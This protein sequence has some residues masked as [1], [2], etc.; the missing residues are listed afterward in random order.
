M[1]WGGVGCGGER[2]GRGGKGWVV[3]VGEGGGEH[4]RFAWHSEVMSVYE[5][6]YTHHLKLW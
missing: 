5:M 6:H 2:E 1:G 4:E 3:G